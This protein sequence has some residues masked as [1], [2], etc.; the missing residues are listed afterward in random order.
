MKFQTAVPAAEHDEFVGKNPLNHLLQSS[1][2]AKVKDNW[3]SKIVG[4]R[5]NSGNLLASS[6]VLIKKLP[7]GFTMFYTPRGPIM[8]YEN[9]ELV[10]FFFDNLK[11]FAK[12][13]RALFIKSDPA[14][15]YRTSKFG[16]KEVA[17]ITPESLEIINNIK[18]SG[19][20]HVGFN[21][22][23]SET[24]QPRFQSNEPL[25][26]KMDLIYP[27]HAK[28]IMKDAVNR[29]VTGRRVGLDKVQAFSDVVSMTESRKGVALRNHDYFE[30]LMTLYGEDAYLHLA[31]V[32]LKEK[33]AA[34]QAQF[35]QLE[36][37]IAATPENQK[38][39]FNRLNDQKKSTEKYL[40]EF[41]DY[42]TTSDKATVIAGILSIKFGD[43]M[44]ML[45][46]GMND[47]F[48]KFYPQYLLYPK[49]FDD[50]FASGAHWANM[51]GVEG[52]LADGLSKF[53]SNFNPDIQELIGEFNFPVNKLFY[54]LS[55]Y[56]YKFRKKMR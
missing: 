24:I 32:N 1:T 46:A 33:Y 40:K 3:D 36:K 4:V 16:Q 54:G 37:D 38:K 50:A 30:Q 2:W 35:V 49:A 53:K 22:T 8:D 42:D 20:Q 51:G 7:L 21:L 28:R 44:E 11:K 10:T 48:K 52:D 27:K 43:T 47:D 14:V 29:G 26:E 18:A 5:D 45:Y 9:V 41:A 17:E 12:K 19:G 39:R 23:M 55:N 13:H 15:I 31:E 6:L 25:N 34:L 56:A